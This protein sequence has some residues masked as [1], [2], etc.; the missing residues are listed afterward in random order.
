MGRESPEGSTRTEGKSRRL[1]A[2][3]AG[4]ELRRRLVGLVSDRPGKTLLV[5]ADHCNLGP[6]EPTID[7]QTANG[8]N[9]NLA[10]RNN[11]RRSGV[12]KRF[13]RR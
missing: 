3:T 2:A 5:C 6:P 4:V 9:E 8:P 10:A 1:V 13:L 12:A 7:E 11:A